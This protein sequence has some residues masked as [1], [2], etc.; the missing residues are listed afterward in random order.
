MS[1]LQARQSE[2]S[3]ELARHQT[4]TTEFE[5]PEQEL[6]GRIG[7]RANQ[8]DLICHVLPRGMRFSQSR[9]TSID[10]Y[11]CEL[12]AYSRQPSVVIAEEIADPLPAPRLIEIPCYNYAR[13]TRRSRF[14]AR[15][16]AE[17]DPTIVSVQQHIPSA[18]HIT[19]LVQQPVIL[20]RHNFLERPAD[21][22]VFSRYRYRSKIAKLNALGGITFVSDVL[23]SHFESHWPDVQVPREV[24]SNG[25]DKRLWQAHPDRDNSILIVGRAAPEKGIAEAAAAVAT[26]LAEKPEWRADFVLSEEAVHPDYHKSIKRLLEPLGRQVSLRLN[27]P[28]AEVK[29]LFERAAIAIVPSK[30][31]EPFGRTCLEAH[32]GGAAVI[33]SGTGGL[34]SISGDQALYIDPANPR[35]IAQALKFLM[36]D[37]DARQA[38]AKGGTERVCR[39]FDID[40]I[41][42]RLD[43]FCSSVSA[44]RSHLSHVDPPSLGNR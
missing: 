31:A 18:V 42:A 10:L 15:K 32:A 5:R 21:D 33:S 37:D 38:L 34:R 44:G 30:W 40:V 20:Q 39:L 7:A 19:S 26:V 17:L 22:N 1:G 16:I 8:P 43:K 3:I 4:A 25:F 36:N 27:R 29:R 12:V 13:T 9:A 23:V 14:I 6:S 2:L 24:I 11:V 35:S 41:A 28:F